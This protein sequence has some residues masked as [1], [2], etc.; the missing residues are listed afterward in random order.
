MT[1]LSDPPARTAIDEDITPARARD[2][3]RM[4]DIRFGDDGPQVVLLQMPL[5]RRVLP[6][7]GD[8]PEAAVAA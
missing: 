7:A 8:L 3:G 5:N 6:R 1:R 2:E 4:L